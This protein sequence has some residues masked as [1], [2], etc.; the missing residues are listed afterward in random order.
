MAWEFTFLRSIVE[1]MQNP[2][3]DF[4]FKVITFLG[5]GGA[6]FFLL[7]FIFVFFKKTRRTGLIILAG[8]IIVAGANQFILKPLVARPRPFLDPTVSADALWLSNHVT[9]WGEL[10]SFNNWLIPHSHSFMSGHT[11]SAFIFGF[12]VLFYHPKWSAP[13][14]IFSFLMGFSRLYFG[15]HFLTDVLAGTLTAFLTILALYF[16]NRRFENTFISWWNAFIGLFKKKK[17][18]AIKEDEESPQVEE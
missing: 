16:I 17:V 7:A 6:I 11:L 15:F 1:N 5:E 10:N 9:A 12:G 18:A 13:A 3:F 14:L 2:F 8:L 4:F